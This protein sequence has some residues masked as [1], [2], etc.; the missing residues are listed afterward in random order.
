MPGMQV[1]RSKEQI[2][3]KFPVCACMK[4]KLMRDLEVVQKNG[5]KLSTAKRFLRNKRGLA[6]V[7]TRCIC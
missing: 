5:Q 3:L 4:R 1:N 2:V 6:R 7:T